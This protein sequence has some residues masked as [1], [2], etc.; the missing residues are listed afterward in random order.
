MDRGSSAIVL[1][2]RDCG[3]CR[4][5]LAKI[6]RWDRAG[7]LRP[8]PIESP[9]GD[10]L[11]A[12]MPP[13]QRLAS[14]HLVLEDGRRYSGGD[15]FAPLL[16]LLPAGAPFGALAG[17]FPRVARMGYG[18]VASRRSPLG[19]RLPRRWVSAADEVVA[20]R[21][22]IRSRTPSSTASIRSEGTKAR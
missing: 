15:A 6:L 19:R 9:E 12:D 10:A 2:D 16:A 21:A 7:R 13:E 1:Y 5:S 18:A 11:L 20:R 14:W 8:V 3:F 4:W 22:A 17:R